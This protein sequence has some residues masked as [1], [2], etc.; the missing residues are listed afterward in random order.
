[1]ATPFETARSA[2]FIQCVGS[3][4]KERPYCSKVCC[5]HSVVSA[6]KLKEVNPEMDV[7]ILY[8]DMRTYGLREDLYREA[9]A[10]GVVFIRYDDNK[11]LKVERDKDDLQVLFTSVS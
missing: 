5:T 1:M 10:K 8:R 6:L 3:R 4:I 9:R 7:Y 11:E 2:V